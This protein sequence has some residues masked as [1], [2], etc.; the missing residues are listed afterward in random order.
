[1]TFSEEAAYQL[2][3]IS[4]MKESRRETVDSKQVVHNFK[5]LGFS[6][7]HLS[8]LPIR[9]IGTHAMENDNSQMEN[10]KSKDPK[11]FTSLLSFDFYCLLVSKFFPAFLEPCIRS[12][13]TTT[14]PD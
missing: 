2:R 9:F 4:A 7:F 12:P 10:G 8:L 13:F 14:A 11:I 6:I 5:V 3:Y 1:M